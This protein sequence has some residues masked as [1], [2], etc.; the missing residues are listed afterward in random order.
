MRPKPV[1]TNA[2]KRLRA[3][4]VL[5][6]FAFTFLPCSAESRA[7][8]AWRNSASSRC[9]V[10][11]P[12]RAVGAVVSTALVSVWMP[13]DAASMALGSPEHGGAGIVVVVVC[14]ALTVVVVEVATMVDEVVVTI[15]EEVV[16]T[17]ADVVLVGT[18]VDVVLVD[19]LAL[20]VVDVLVTVVCVV[21]VDVVVTRSVVVVGTLVLVVTVIV[22]LVLVV[23][24][25]VV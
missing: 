25:V 24:V 9:A 5:P 14:S 11:E 4:R 16:G 19:D 1:C 10:R 7:S 23:D 13:H 17:T 8:L 20:V 2:S 6:R 22:V 21:E 3:R 18:M 15:V 12:P